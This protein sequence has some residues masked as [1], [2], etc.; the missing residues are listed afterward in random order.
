M[1]FKHFI[2][3]VPAL[4]LTIVLNTGCS[5]DRDPTNNTVVPNSEIINA[6][7]QQFPEAKNVVWNKKMEYYVASFDMPQNSTNPNGDRLNKA[8]YTETGDC[9]LSEIEIPVNDLPQ[10]ILQ[11]FESSDYKAIGYIIDDVDLLT[12]GEEKKYKLEIEAE[13]KEDVDLYYAFDGTFLYEKVDKD[14]NSESAPIPG[15]ATDFIKQKYPEAV[16]LESES[17]EK[18]GTYEIDITIKEIEMEV[19]FDFKGNWLHTS[20][21]I[22]LSL[23]P[24]EVM[25]TLKNI[26]GPNDE[27]DNI[28]KW[29]TP[30]GIQYVIEV[31][32]ETENKEFTYIFNEKGEQIKK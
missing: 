7:K 9:S 18:T 30:N 19:V 14:G 6:F 26:L 20:T 29:E 31:E 28:E 16:I 3:I 10:N 17:D 13:G 27:T 12:R 11:H 23:L 32:N 4:I 21:E 25:T 22:E 15:F 24:N 8:W 1:K 5:N 2:F